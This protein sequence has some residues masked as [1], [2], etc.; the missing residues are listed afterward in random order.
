MG[1]AGVSNYGT[2]NIPAILLKVEVDLQFPVKMSLWNAP[3]PL[4]ASLSEASDAGLD[5]MAA[6]GVVGKLGELHSMWVNCE[7]CYCWWRKGRRCAFCYYAMAAN[8]FRMT[9][10]DEGI[11]WIRRRWRRQRHRW[12]ACKEASMMNNVTN[13]DKY[14]ISRA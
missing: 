9:D 4:I 8:G 5:K 10:D 12:Y 13:P 11:L 2:T 6:F 1:G 14:V 7:H 3:W